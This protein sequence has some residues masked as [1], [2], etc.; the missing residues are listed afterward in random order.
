[1]T[2]ADYR[3]RPQFT[4]G[5]RIEAAFDRPAHVVAIGDGKVPFRTWTERTPAS[6]GLSDHDARRPLEFVRP[7]PAA[8]PARQFSADPLLRHPSQPLPEAE[9]RAVCRQLLDMPP[10]AIPV[11]APPDSPEPPERRWPACGRGCM[12]LIALV[13]PLEDDTS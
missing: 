4:L 2:L 7:L 3:R 5:A 12:L 10:A 8:R 13:L 9:P 1:M 11:E 6:D